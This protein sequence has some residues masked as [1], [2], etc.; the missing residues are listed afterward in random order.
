MSEIFKE[1]KSCKHCNSELKE[2]VYEIIEPDKTGYFNRYFCDKYV[3]M[4]HF[5]EPKEKPPKTKKT[6]RKRKSKKEK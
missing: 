4:F 2:I 5:R 1:I 6:T 3:R